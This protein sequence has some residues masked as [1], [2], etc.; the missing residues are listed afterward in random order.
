V[1]SE[2][3]GQLSFVKGGEIFHGLSVVEIR[4]MLN[5]HLLGMSLEE[6]AKEKPKVKQ[7][8][9]PKKEKNVSA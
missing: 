6:S 1:V 3:T 7:Q 2:E 9:P 5:A 8:S 4:R